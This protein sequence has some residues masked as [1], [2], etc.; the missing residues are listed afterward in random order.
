MTIFF[1]TKILIK[2][3]LPW[4]KT[5][6]LTFLKNLTSYFMTSWRSQVRRSDFTWVRMYLS[7]HLVHHVTQRM[8]KHTWKLIELKSVDLQTVNNSDLSLSDYGNK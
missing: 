7:H 2:L 4:E 1:L 5:Q 8:P 3:S 6:H